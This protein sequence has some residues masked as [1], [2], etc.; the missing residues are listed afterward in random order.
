MNKK[1]ARGFDCINALKDSEGFLDISEFYLKKD[2]KYTGECKQCL[3]EKQKKY[4]KLHAKEK[5]E[6]DK[7][8]EKLNK[9]KIKE[10]KH[11]YRLEHLD[12]YTKKDQE[13]YEKHKES[14]HKYN[15]EYSKKRRKTDIQ[16][17]LKTSLRSRLGNALRIYRTTKK[18]SSIKDLGCS[19]EFFVKY[20]ESKFLSGMSWSNYGTG[21]GLWNLDHI[22]AL[23]NFDLIDLEQQKLAVHYTNLQPLWNDDNIRKSNKI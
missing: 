10:R 16:Y 4:Y 2:K 8:Y 5:R 17:K 22:K 7:E 3:V 14:R 6:Y 19:I 11:N 21:K 13:Y 20:I 23:A 12:K 18:V 15:N 1:C 9:E